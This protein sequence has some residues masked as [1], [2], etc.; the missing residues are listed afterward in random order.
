MRINQSAII[1]K[2]TLFKAINTHAQ[3]ST[4]EIGWVV[5]RVCFSSP[6]GHT[7]IDKRICSH[8]LSTELSIHRLYPFTCEVSRS[9]PGVVVN[10]MD[11]YIEEIEFELQSC[12]YVLFRSN[13]LGKSI[14][15]IIP[16][17]YGINSTTI[18][19]FQWNLWN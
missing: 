5:S 3:L 11:C 8:D 13:A 6:D 18:I 16:P 19:V 10:V 17:D 15:P 12:R 14:N 9:V 1:I 2:S 4:T 7:L